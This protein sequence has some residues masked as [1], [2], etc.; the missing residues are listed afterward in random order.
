MVTHIDER[1]GLVKVFW[2]DIRERV[3]NVEPKFAELVDALAPDKTFP[4][5]L[6][7]YPYGAMKGDTEHHFMPNPD[8]SL[9]SLSDPHAPKDVIKHLGYGADSSPMGMVL[10]KSVELF[11]DLKEKGVTIPWTIYE[12]GSFF[13]FSKTLNQRVKTRYNTNKLK[14]SCGARSTLMLPNIGCMTNHVNLQRDFNIQSSPAK[15][16]YDHWHVFKE[17]TNSPLV[18]SD[19][20][21]CLLYFSEKWLDKMHNDIGWVRLKLYMHELAWQHFEF[22]R[23]RI[24]YDMA[25]SLIQ[26][27]RNLKPNPYLADTARHL[28]ATAV[29][30]V[31]GYV[32]AKSNDFLPLD[33]LQEVFTHCYGLKKYFPTIIQPGKFNVETSNE[34]VYYSLQYPATYVFSPK[35]RKIFTALTEM[36]ELSHIMKIITKEFTTADAF[37]SDTIFNKIS[38]DIQFFYFH[39]EEDMHHVIRPTKEILTMDKRFDRTDTMSSNSEATFAKDATFLRGCIA[40]CKNNQ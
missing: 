30:A 23:N 27:K 36:R 21:A 6:A 13:S 26:Q 8:G 16:L 29:G 39:N 33:I 10:E 14:A 12:A 4:L 18:K 28:F 5:Y 35:S 31:P 24:F 38:K 2:Q 34:P 7:Y 40:I 19:W 3:K 1:K 15:S 11:V 22:E 20:Q 25:F 32:P 9:Y 37:C 17:I